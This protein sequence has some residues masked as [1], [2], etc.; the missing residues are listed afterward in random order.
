M[1]ECR[2]VQ[3]DPSP[4]SLSRLEPEH[5]FY[6]EPIV[7]FSQAA[8]R[9]APRSTQRVVQFL[10]SLAGSVTGTLLLLWPAA[11][12][13]SVLAIGLAAMLVVPLRGRWAWRWEATIIADAKRQADEMASILGDAPTQRSGADWLA[14]SPDAPVDD[15]YR[16]LGFIGHDELAEQLIP[17]LPTGT[18][19]ERFWRPGQRSAAT[20]G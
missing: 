7:T 5:G 8:F 3:S 19:E 17:E 2:V 1:P 18:P 13:V 20:G 16:V 11:V 15:R 12:A 14:R 10:A 6:W 4:V 9:P